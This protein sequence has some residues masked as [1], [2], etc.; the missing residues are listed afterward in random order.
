MGAPSITQAQMRRAIEA[1]KPHGWTVE[2]EPRRGI[3]RLVPAAPDALAWG[4]GNDGGSGCDEVFGVV[5]N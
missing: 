2:V 3:I 1:A 4:P 5:R